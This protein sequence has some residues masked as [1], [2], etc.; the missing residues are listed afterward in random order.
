MHWRVTC[1]Q[2]NCLV[3]C[4]GDIIVFVLCCFVSVSQN[5]LVHLHRRA[6]KMLENRGQFD[7]DNFADCLAK[8]LV[9]SEVEPQVVRSFLSECNS[10]Y[11]VM[12]IAKQFY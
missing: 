7:F 12:K 8:L 5:S 10:E 9:V 3:Y 11:E 2:L 4:V 6:L 1:S